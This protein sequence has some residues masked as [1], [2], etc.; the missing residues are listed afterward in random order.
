MTG[1]GDDDDGGDVAGERGGAVTEV[2]RP[3]EARAWVRTRAE[4]AGCA[5]GVVD[6]LVLLVS[7]VLVAD[8][9]RSRA[10]SGPRLLRALPT[11]DGFVVEVSLPG[12]LLPLP[13]R[14]AD[15]GTARLAVAAAATTVTV[16]ESRPGDEGGQWVCVTVRT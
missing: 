12:P 15:D 2:E 6:E 5:A 10:A 9:A 16:L 8:A 1:S 14:P 7:E 3:A 13:D 11:R 4:A